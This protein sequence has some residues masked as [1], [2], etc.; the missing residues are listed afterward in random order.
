MSL[1][2]LELLMFYLNSTNQSYCS[3]ALIYFIV[4]HMIWGLNTV[5]SVVTVCSSPLSWDSTNWCA[6]PFYWNK[7]MAW[8]NTKP[9]TDC[10]KDNTM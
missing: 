9:K 6:E 2:S 10:N 8:C 1:I 5:S 7:R 4:F 3:Q